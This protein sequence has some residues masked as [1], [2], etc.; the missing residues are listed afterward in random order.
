MISQVWEM[1]SQVWEMISQ[2]WEMISHMCLETSFFW[3]SPFPAEKNHLSQIM[4]DFFDLLQNGEM[5]V[6]AGL[7]RL[8][9]DHNT[10][11]RIISVF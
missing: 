3:G 9:N 6:F 8:Q 10:D 5:P 1:I 11:I 4:N 2:V 7:E